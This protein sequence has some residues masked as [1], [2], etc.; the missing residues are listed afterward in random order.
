TIVYRASPFAEPVT[1]YATS[2]VTDTAQ[3]NWNVG[4]S[5]LSALAPTA[6][7]DTIGEIP[8][9]PHSHYGL[10]TLISQ[11]YNTAD[12]VYAKYNTTLKV[13]DMS[14]QMGGQ[15]DLA[16]SAWRSD[17]SHI[18]HRAGRSADIRTTGGPGNGLITPKERSFARSHWDSFPNSMVIVEG[19]HY[20]FRYWGST[21]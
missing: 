20:H 1:L 12:A 17:T 18:E 8:P 13:N 5:G 2:A 6:H 10:P 21:P 3:A 14:L 11:L 4:V 9:H 16:Y 7:L 15:F 19:D